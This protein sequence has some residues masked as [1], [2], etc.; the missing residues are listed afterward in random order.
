MSTPAKHAR[1]RW[2]LGKDTVVILLFHGL[3]VDIVQ[4]SVKS[5]DSR[6]NDFLLKFPWESMSKLLQGLH[7]SA[8]S[9]STSGLF[10]AAV[11]SSPSSKQQ[12]ASPASSVGYLLLWV[13]DLQNGTWKMISG[14]RIHSSFTEMCAI[15]GH[16]LSGVCMDWTANDFLVL[17]IP[18][19]TE[20][21][22]DVSLVA[23]SPGE[24]LQGTLA[25]SL[26]NRSHRLVTGEAVV[27][28]LRV[29]HDASNNPQMDLHASS[30]AVADPNRPKTPM[31]HAVLWS[32][33]KLNLL[34]VEVARNVTSILWTNVRIAPCLCIDRHDALYVQEIGPRG[35]YLSLDV[36]AV[37]SAHQTE[38]SSASA[39]ASAVRPVDACKSR[40]SI[41]VGLDSFGGVRVGLINIGD[42]GSNMVSGAS[43]KFS[44]S[45][46]S[47]SLLNLSKAVDAHLAAAHAFGVSLLLMLEICMF[48][49]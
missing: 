26:H 49:Y 36:A 16:V 24:L 39:A 32:Q 17:A 1:H 41:F 34:A 30:T 11:L 35:P 13:Q 33:L 2:F 29:L 6:M 43:K 14:A 21:T 3:T 45:T 44:K 28:G 8:L 38:A 15:S 5:L 22:E 10:A 4:I 27:S 23:L 47:R 37:L 48:A 12:P 42:S 20:T 7:V 9:L 46:S 31:I 18:S 40:H 25:Q 19:I